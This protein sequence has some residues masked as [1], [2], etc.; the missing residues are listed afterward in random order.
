M[1]SNTG[2]KMGNKIGNK[3]MAITVHIKAKMLRRKMPIPV[4][5]KNNNVATQIKTIDE[6]AMLH[7]PAETAIVIPSIGS[8]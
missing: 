5:T 8:I 4:N 6:T 2:I 3:I 7:K 1:I